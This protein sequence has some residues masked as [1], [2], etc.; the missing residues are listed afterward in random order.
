[1]TEWRR[2]EEKSMANARHATEAAE[3][4]NVEACS[5]GERGLPGRR[6]GWERGQG[7]VRVFVFDSYLVLL[8]AGIFSSCLF[9]S[10]WTFVWWTGERE[11]AES[12]RCCFLFSLLRS[13]V[14]FFRAGLQ[15]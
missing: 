6:R 15:H 12:V 13:F 11:T 3:E 8:T 10:R 7:K 9:E 5:A 2:N 4:A 1:M 14:C